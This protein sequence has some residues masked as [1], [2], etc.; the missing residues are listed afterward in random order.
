MHYSKIA[1]YFRN[2]MFRNIYDL[3]GVE[4]T[5]NHRSLGVIVQRGCYC[6]YTCFLYN[7]GTVCPYSTKPVRLT[8]AQNTPLDLP[9]MTTKIQP[10]RDGH[11]PV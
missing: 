7:V 4:N 6:V 5:K 9:A 2:I 1:T 10:F 3:M 8:S 11:Q